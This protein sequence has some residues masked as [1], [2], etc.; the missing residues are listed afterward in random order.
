[1]GNAVHALADAFIDEPAPATD[2]APAQ[3][4]ATP[5]PE[6]VVPAS[7]GPAPLQRQ[8]AQESA[9]LA[10]IKALGHDPQHLPKNQPGKRGV[11][12]DV[13]DALG[14][15]PMLKDGTKFDKCWERLTGFG[16][17]KYEN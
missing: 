5:A 2:T 3:T 4:T 6:A 7:D 8:Q 16:D 13:R 9:V 10:Q 15:N 12:A 17:L 11:K 1:M 14:D